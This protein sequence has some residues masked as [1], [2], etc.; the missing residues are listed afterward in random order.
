MDTA[1]H[2]GSTLLQV[3]ERGRYEFSGWCENDCRIQ[4]FGGISGPRPGPFGSQFPREI[5]MPN[6][7]GESEYFHAPMLGHLDRDVRRVAESIGS[8]RVSA[9]SST[10]AGRVRT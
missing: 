1:E 2:Y 8:T 3:P 10:W 9:R 4:L 5:L 6:V 7:A